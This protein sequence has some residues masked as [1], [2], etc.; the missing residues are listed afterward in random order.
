MANSD[1]SSQRL[2]NTIAGGGGI[3]LVADRGALR[4]S[5]CREK[6]SAFLPFSRTYKINYGWQMEMIGD[7][8]LVSAMKPKS[9]AEA[10]GLKVGDVVQSIDG[11]KPSREIIWK[12][13]Y[14]YYV[15]HFFPD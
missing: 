3:L 5:G 8:C 9:D 7:S 14:F 10:K 15:R 11:F 12:M 13:K 2:L 6:A 4:G 1:S